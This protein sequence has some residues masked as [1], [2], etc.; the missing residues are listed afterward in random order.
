MIPPGVKG[1]AVAQFGRLKFPI[2][3][4]LSLCSGV[5]KVMPAGKY[6]VETAVVEVEEGGKQMKVELFQRLGHEWWRTSA[7]V[8]ALGRKCSIS[9]PI[10]GDGQCERHDLLWSDFAARMLR[11][12]H[13][14][15]ACA[16]SSG[17]HARAMP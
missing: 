9:A 2:G 8:F 5:T 16:G 4:I 14:S 12:P 10:Q 7:G 17:Q 11:A 1:R 6:T 3:F 15:S 13:R